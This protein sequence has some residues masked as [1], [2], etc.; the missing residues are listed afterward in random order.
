MDQVNVY[1]GADRM[2]TALG[3]TTR[4]TFQAIQS[5]TLGVRAV[6]DPSLSMQPLVAGRID[7]SGVEHIA[8]HTFLEDLLHAAVG[9]VLSE[10]QL[11]P[12]EVQLIVATTKGNIEALAEDLAPDERCFISEGIERFARELGF[13]A[14]PI[15][16]S[17]ACISGLVAL[18]VARR[19]ILAEKCHHVV[20]A[21]VDTLSEFV[22][23][24]FQSFKSVSAKVCRPYDRS[25]DG[26]SLGE[27]CGA[28]LLTDD[29]ARAKAGAVR[30]AGGAMTEDAN[31]LS[32][33]SRTGEEL[34]E[35]MLQAITEAGLTAEDIDL[36]NAHGTA[37]AYNDEMESKAIAVAGLL[38]KPLN[39]L[40]PYL[41]HTLGASGVVEA[42]L[43]AEELRHGVSFATPGFEECGVPH[44][45]NVSSEH[46][47]GDFRT[48]L[49]SGS[50]FGGCNAAVVLTRLD[51]NVPNVAQNRKVRCTATYELHGAGDFAERIRQEYRAL[52]QPNMRFFKMDDLEKLGYV[53]A[54]NLLRG[55][56]LS[57]EYGAFRVGIILANRS[58]SL[59]TDIR[60]Q[61]VVNAHP[62]EG[63]SP[64]I[65]VYT[66]PNIV[67]GELSIRH[68]IK[69]ES[70]FFIDS[71]PAHPFV[72]GYAHALIASGRLDAVVEGWCEYLNGTY[73]V[74]I[75]ILEKQ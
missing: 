53:A 35:A 8:G 15:T 67:A 55:R 38:D 10:A 46:R 61:E 68:K 5:G 64:A 26:L 20:V 23:A 58:A 28:V 11:D 13:A 60:H 69:G 45:V 50:G 2:I 37:T 7:R 73:C 44:A 3:A 30:I 71:D 75:N 49:K 33:P 42:I 47:R 29:P 43:S 12:K 66:L 51:R 22:V 21:G 24:G 32:A 59:S 70:I 41:G 57:E 62:E 36:V 14:K 6:N 1:M 48:A 18:I 74:H 39:S 52:A 17:N 56:N 25:R 34:A 40:K 4:D 54:E 9:S 16:I 65:F 63:A 31:H 72:E 19:M 27:A